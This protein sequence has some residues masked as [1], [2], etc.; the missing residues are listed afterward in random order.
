MELPEQLQQAL[1]GKYEIVRTLG[2]G[3]M[4]TVYLARDVRHGRDVALKVLHPDLGSA[5]GPERFQREI[6]L[7]ARLQHPHI[8]TVL[9][10]GED[11]GRLWFTMPFVEG[12][13]LRDRLTRERQ[14]PV[15]DAVRIATQ[16]A[17]ALRY[18]HQHG[19]IHRDIKPENLLLTEDG[20]TLVADFGIARSLS[21]GGSKLTETGVT[22]GTPAYMSPEQAS[23]ESDVSALS[24]IYSLGTVLYE[25]LAGEPPF[26]GPT[27]QAVIA[28]RF[29]STAPDVRL[30]RPAVPEPVALAVAQ[31]LAPV[32]ADRFA[33]AA[34][35]ARALGSATATAAATATTSAV[36]GPAPSVTASAAD[37]AVSKG[38]PGGRVPLLSRRPLFA[39]LV[40]GVAIGLGLLFGW[41]RTHNTVRSNGTRLI[42][43]LPFENVGD[44]SD[45]YFA[46]GITDAV[47]GKLTALS[48]LR[49]TAANSS[50]EY[51]K[52]QKSLREIASE[53]GV[54]YLLVGKVR[55]AKAADGTNRV[56]V[57][58]QLIQASSE[59]AK[60]QQSFDAPLTDV[61]Q[62]Q[63]DIAGRVASALN[64]AL[65]DSAQRQL[66][67]R[68]TAN[69]AAYDAFLRGDA[70]SGK[71]SSADP[72]AL[73]RA[74]EYYSQ[75]TAIDPGFHLAWSRMARTFA[76]LYFTG[77]T[78]NE[79]G[80]LSRKAADRALELAPDHAD[81]HL[82]FGDYY[83]LVAGDFQRARG[84]Y[85]EGLR[86]SPSDADLLT[87]AALNQQSLGQW[88]AALVSL[89][90]A[91]ILDPRAVVTGRRL[92]FTLLGLRRYAEAQE[93]ADRTL[94]LAPDNIPVLEVRAMIDL[95]KG[96][97]AAARALVAT[98]G[99]RIDPTALVSHFAMYWDLYWLLDDAQQQLLLRLSPAAF[100]DEGNR[101]IVLAQTYQLRGDSL[102]MRAYADT[103]RVAFERTMSS[104]PLDAQR[105][106]FH[107]LSLAY[108]GRRAEA[109]REGKKAV[110]L[111]PASKDGY[112]GPYFQHMLV[113]I[114]LLTGE[115][116][117][118]LDALEPLLKIPYFLSPGWLKVDPTFAPLRA[119]PR[120]QKLVAGGG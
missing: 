107:G 49:V 6:R 31:A 101:S 53:L 63:A 2:A 86:L 65:V 114:Y 109:I 5:L 34:D 11:L 85:D 98:S 43:V 40:L 18:A 119:E 42:A 37:Q 61:F 71:L 48:G 68:P 39:A 50:G 87:G 105:R 118:A 15:A 29:T 89:R 38:E 33:N 106:A 74:S 83:S 4:A 47:R 76:I 8:L 23:G 21:L 27:A 77:S 75:A 59:D 97:D 30:A 44:T 22:L 56:Q 64:V 88:D 117:K 110:E 69:L 78:S 1:V 26:T 12:E 24:D 79:I 7:A 103:A 102:K 13:S 82:A 41:S 80:E 54:D 60:W 36:K 92:A 19:V 62:V 99:A 108:L 10:S 66:A 116:Q 111:Q 90:R 58:P 32:P 84:E 120:F 70:I 57:S 72:L 73:R 81:G 35:F 16:A 96:D 113:R 55:W 93:V 3:G 20:N 28:K 94:A 17:Q 25:M 91:A 112:S 52:S 9:D 14:L 45:A 95:G 46:D 115:K 67:E 100:A 51:R 104:V